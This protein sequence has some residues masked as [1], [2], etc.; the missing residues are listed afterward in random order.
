MFHSMII[1]LEFRQIAYGPSLWPTFPLLLSTLFNK[2]FIEMASNSTISFIY[3]FFCLFVMPLVCI[4]VQEGK[5]SFSGLMGLGCGCLWLF[6]NFQFWAGFWIWHWWFNLLGAVVLSYLCLC[7][8]VWVVLGHAF[9]GVV[10]SN[11]LLDELKYVSMFLVKCGTKVAI[12]KV[13]YVFSMLFQSDDPLDLVRLWIYHRFKAG[14]AHS[15]LSI[16]KENM[17]Q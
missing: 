11:V 7:L 9:A 15:R 14:R 3:C 5:G 4:V 13:C 2:V 12:F 1:F 17:V 8:F 10:G 16:T 6:C